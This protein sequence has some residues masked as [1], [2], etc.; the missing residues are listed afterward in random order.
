MGAV[1]LGAP[2]EGG[3]G[4]GCIGGVVGDEVGVVVTTVAPLE[5]SVCVDEY[6]LVVFV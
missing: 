6:I 2:L 4:S 1:Q 5:V 3:G